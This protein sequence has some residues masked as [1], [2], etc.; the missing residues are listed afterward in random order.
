MSECGIGPDA[1]DILVTVD[2]C[3][4]FPD[5]SEQKNNEMDVSRNSSEDEN[6]EDPDWNSEEWEEEMSSEEES[7]EWHKLPAL[8]F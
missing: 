6:F 4:Q 1:D 3:Y 8:L 7:E 2:K 5:E